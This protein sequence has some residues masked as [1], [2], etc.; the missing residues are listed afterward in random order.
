MKALMITLV[1]TG[2]VAS[3]LLY[4]AFPADEVSSNGHPGV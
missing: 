2:V 4:Q 3:F 1:V